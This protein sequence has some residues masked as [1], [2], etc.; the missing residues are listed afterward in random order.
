MDRD[1]AAELNER[2]PRLADQVAQAEERADH[3]LPT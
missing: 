3:Q 1:R 2:I